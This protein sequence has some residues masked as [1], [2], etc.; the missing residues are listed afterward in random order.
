MKFMKWIVVFQWIGIL[1]ASAQDIRVKG[2]VIPLFEHALATEFA[3]HP[4]WSVQLGYQNHIELGDNVYY[5]HRLT[6]SFRYYIR[7]DRG[8]VDGLFAEAFHRSTFIRHIP[9]QS[10]VRLKKY[11]SQSIGF[12]LGK[13]HFFR[14]RNMFMEWSVGRYLIYHGN[15]WI[16]RPRFD[17][18][19]HGD[20][21]RTRLDFKL[22]LRLRSRQRE[23]VAN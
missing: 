5:H 3:F 12:A 20:D 14:S 22:G 19:I 4:N 18:F 15:S 1:G 8:V 7:S 16:D 6:P 10:D 23:V 11:Q 21:G 17:M 13:Q 9:D 2:L